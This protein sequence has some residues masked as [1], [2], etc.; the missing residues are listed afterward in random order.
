VIT[1]DDVNQDIEP[2][3]VA[4]ILQA[5]VI[6]EKIEL[7]LCGKQAI[8]NDMN[9]TACFPHRISSILSSITIACKIFATSSGSISW[10]TSSVVI[11]NIAQSSYF[12]MI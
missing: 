9:A 4:K 1:T 2:L 10:L 3:D 8:D 7:I 11:T 12:K 6:E 5:I